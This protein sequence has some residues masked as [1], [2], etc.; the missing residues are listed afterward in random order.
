MLTRDRDFSEGN[1]ELDDEIKMKGGS[2]ADAILLKM[3]KTFAIRLQSNIIYH[4]LSS[5]KIL[6]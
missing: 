2:G 1:E 6:H 3:L 4:L 5:F